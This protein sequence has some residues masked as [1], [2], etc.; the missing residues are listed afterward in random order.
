MAALMTLDTL[1]AALKAAATTTTTFTPTQPLS[2]TQYKAGFDVFIQGIGWATYKDFVIPKLRELLSPLFDSCSHIAVLEIGPGPKSVLEHLPMSMRHRI[3]KYSAFEPNE[4]FAASLE[5]TLWATGGPKKSLPRLRSPPDIHREPFTLQSGIQDDQNSENEKFNVILFCQ[6]MYGMTPKH[7]FINRALE[8]LVEQPDSGRVVVFHRHR[9]LSLD[10]LVC[11]RTAF[12]PNGVIGVTDNDKTLDCFSAF[13]AGFVVQ[14]PDAHEQLCG[15]WRGVC[16][17]LGRKAPGNILLFGSPVMMLAF[18][19]HAAALSKLETWI[20]SAVK[21]RAIKNP[22]A[23]LYHNVRIVRPTEVEHIQRCVQ[24]AVKHQVGLTVFGG[25]HSGQC[26]WPNAVSVDMGAFDEV[27]VITDGEEG[28]KAH[29]GALVVAGGGCKTRDIIGATMAAGLTVPLGSRP[30]VGAGLWLQGGIG[31]L[32]RI[33]GLAC[34]AIVGAVVVSVD[35][36]HIFC[37]G[38]VP[39]Q[40]RPA[41]S[42]CPE[43]GDDLL[44]ALRGAGTNFGIVVSVTFKAFAAPTYSVRNWVIP[45]R[46][47]PEAQLKLKEFD[48]MIA[49]KLEWD[50]SAD[51]YL[52]SSS[53]QLH[54][55]VA[56]YGVSATQA[57]FE[58]PTHIDSILGSQRVSKIVDG[59]GLFD[60]EMY[61]SEMHGGH[62][63]GK[64]S[65]F[66]RCLF[67]KHIGAADIANVLVAALENRPSP[68]CYL[69]LL[70]GGGA[71][72]D[73]AP[74]VTAFGCRDW[75]FACVITGVWPRDQDGTES[76][77]AS[78]DW[79]YSIT[80]DLLP[81][82]SGAYGADLGPDPR[83]AVLATKAFGPNQSRLARLKACFDPHDILAYA[84]PLL[85]ASAEQ[86]FQKLIILVTGESCAGKDFCGQFWAELFN[87]CTDKTVRAR[88]VS[89]SDSTK[90]EYAAATGADL[91]RLLE[92]RNYKEQH[93]AALTAYFHDQVRQRPQLP[94]EHFLEVVRGAADVDVLL[95]TGMRDEA[96][97]AKLSH[98][99][100]DSRLIE[101]YVRA[102]DETRQARG[103]RG[104]NGDQQ[105]KEKEVVDGMSCPPGLVYQPSFVF[106]NDKMGTQAARTFAEESLLPFLTEDLQRLA[107]MVRSIPNFPRQG[108]EFRHVLDVAQQRGG[109]SLCTSLLRSHFRGD[110]SKVDAMAC[111]EAGGYVFAAALALELDIPLALIREAGKLA[112]PTVSV[113]KHASHVSSLGSDEPGAKTIEM[114]RNVI[115]SEASVVVVD[116]VLATGRTLCAV[117][118][119]LEKAGVNIGNVSVIVVAEFPIHRGRQMLR[120]CGFGGVCVQSL[121][122]FNGV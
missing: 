66:K 59:V 63:G 27:H 6:S 24:W 72:V 64:T 96:P 98:L 99:V 44:W 18:S 32:A 82:C 53:G 41:G 56:V 114:N 101:V 10:G 19:R 7:S 15:L 105:T 109:L 39:K 69:H 11:H 87:A 58:L 107:S 47:R 26:L 78:V 100:A 68:L 113:A 54:L 118:K 21:Q 34:D 38:Q 57:T 111:C 79:V 85:K 35:S 104:S 65:S 8:M 115:P 16:R 12:F 42:V 120:S 48:E 9:P 49:K 23:R 70:Q 91:N 25:G 71:I 112:P 122:V 29:K 77:K 13:A 17:A 76:A 62:G 43:N 67:L 81:L 37:I 46:D 93:R 36:G 28:G 1:R 3:T 121:L 55:G 116:D 4:L 45:L 30:S 89:I 75:D 5:Q 2:D 97:V 31:H 33:H 119:L 103:G 117:L 94:E 90:R 102:S 83:D 50:W 86:S 22:E 60:A 51:A 52:Y 92:D 80:R 110:W 74:E 84:C 73:K 108:I 20:P 61:M 40:H 88:A 95:V 106:D 14:N